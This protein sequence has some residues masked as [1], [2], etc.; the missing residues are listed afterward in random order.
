MQSSRSHREV[1]LPCDFEHQSNNEQP[2]VEST[3]TIEELE[4]SKQDD[5]QA[6]RKRTKGDQTSGS[7]ESTVQNKKSNHTSKQHTYTYTCPECQSELEST[8][9][10]GNI[11]IRHVTKKG[12]ACTRQFKVENGAVAVKQFMCFEHKSC[13]MKTADSYGVSRGEKPEKVR[14]KRC[15][16]HFRF[17]GLED[18]W[19]TSDP[20]GC[21]KAKAK[22]K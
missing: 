20:G 5:D 10:T 6:A 16:A 7:T 15:A 11:N 8:V 2:A 19:P 13:G 3:S 21:R 18:S 4:T 22:N 1:Q 17:S 9:C 12:Q 14:C